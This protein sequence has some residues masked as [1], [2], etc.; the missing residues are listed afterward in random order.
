M[1]SGIDIVVEYPGPKLYV[2][3][4][5]TQYVTR[6]VTAVTTAYAPTRV[7]TSIVVSPVYR[8]VT[9]PLYRYYETW[10]RQWDAYQ[11]AWKEW[12]EK[13]EE[14]IRSGN[15]TLTEYSK[16]VSEKMTNEAR[17]VLARAIAELVVM[18]ESL[19]EDLYKKLRQVLENAYRGL[20]EGKTRIVV[21]P[22]I[23]KDRIELDVSVPHDLLLA[24]ALAG[25][26]HRKFNEY[27]ELVANEVANLGP[28]QAAEAVRMCLPKKVEELAKLVEE[29][30]LDQ[31]KPPQWTEWWWQ[32]A[33]AIKLVT[34]QELFDRAR[35]ILSQWERQGEELA[36]RGDIKGQLMQIA[37]AALKTALSGAQG[38][39]YALL[40]DLTGG[41]FAAPL[42]ADLAN[43]LNQLGNPLVRDL[44]L[45]ELREDPNALAE[46]IGSLVA[47][48]AAGAI[49][50]RAAGLART[51]LAKAVARI[52]KRTGSIK[53]AKL[54]EMIRGFTPQEAAKIVGDFVP[55]RVETKF[56]DT[57]YDPS[58]GRTYVVIFY[59]EAGKIKPYAKIPVEMLKNAAM[60][61]SRVVKVGDEN[62]AAHQILAYIAKRNLKPEEIQNLLEI[63]YQIPLETRS[64]MEFLQALEDAI[65]SGRPIYISGTK[66]KTVAIPAKSD[67][68]IDLEV[69]VDGR[70]LRFQ[71]PADPTA[72]PRV[73]LDPKLIEAADEL[74]KKENIPLSVALYRVLKERGVLKQMRDVVRWLEQ[75][76]DDL[77]ITNAKAVEEALSAPYPV[78]LEESTLLIKPAEGRVVTVAV[79]RG[80]IAE[81]LKYVTGR[82]V[83]DR[84]VSTMV[85]R[86]VA[87]TKPSGEVGDIYY[88]I[89]QKVMIS[90]D[91][92]RE[93]E[94]YFRKFVDAVTKRR[95][96]EAAQYVKQIVETAAK[97]EPETAVELGKLLESMVTTTRRG[98]VVVP[99]PVSDP[100]GTTVTI[101]GVVA[102]TPSQIESAIQRAERGEKVGEA[103]G[104]SAVAMQELK[105]VAEALKQYGISLEV[106]K[107]IDIDRVIAELQQAKQSIETAAEELQDEG[108][109]QLADYLQKTIID[110]AQ[111]KSLLLS[112]NRV[113]NRVVTAETITS[114]SM[115]E[116][117]PMQEARYRVLN[118][119]ARIDTAINVV[120]TVMTQVLDRVVRHILRETQR[121][122]LSKE[123]SL[124]ADV[125]TRRDIHVVAERHL[126]TVDEVLRHRQ[127]IDRIT[128]LSRENNVGEEVETKR[129]ISVVAEKHLKTVD[130][131]LRETQRLTE[132]KH[133]AKERELDASVETKRNIDVVAEKRLKQVDEVL[134]KTLPMLERERLT[135]ESELPT[136]AETDRS[137]NV[138]AEKH[139]KSIDRVVKQTLGIDRL[140]KLAKERSIDED[141]E[142]RRSISVVAE[143]HEKTVDEILR[144]TLGLS[145]V[146]SRSESTAVEKDVASKRDIK[147]VAERLVKMVD[148]ARYDRLAR[149]LVVELAD[150][151]RRYG[152]KLVERDIDIVAT[153]VRPDVVVFRRRRSTVSPI[154]QS[155]ST[156][157]PREETTDIELEVVNREV[158]DTQKVSTTTRS[159]SLTELS[160][161]TSVG[162]EESTQGVVVVVTQPVLE[163]VTEVVPVLDEVWLSWRRLPRVRRVSRPPSLPMVAAVPRIRR[164]WRKGRVGERVVL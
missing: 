81:L 75:H 1:S 30:K 18:S 74:A 2:T 103:V 90:R 51:L 161:C 140:T 87:E 58:T 79:G 33:R 141:V 158:T 80:R 29:G 102:A 49:G 116:T 88:T 149:R 99:M 123:T 13:Q 26:I 136:A 44:L 115:S 72:A 127:D 55:D 35:Q 62:Y 66:V 109:Q 34:L 85:Q 106:G 112:I 91:L 151:L 162:T 8:Y 96:D 97:T 69:A 89:R 124:S 113:V 128:K 110:L 42:L 31:V 37:A 131:V 142:T 117:L 40:I 93:I 135:K 118:A 73:W 107:R 71:I 111:L 67:K 46:F 105:S 150:E 10:Q 38:A 77:R 50:A 59:E 137:I 164:V 6:H 104:R 41:L 133:L 119:I 76:L 129:T 82:S 12:W 70:I 7:I 24:L 52:A 159:T 78:F 28:E 130:E 68:F 114:T 21:T 134:R 64:Q 122:K 146:E 14:T 63:V 32:V 9:V 148:D 92:W 126:K 94:P 86:V 147:V 19:P 98:S 47:G 139:L 144:S 156:S 65:R 45:K 57:V 108:L 154:D 16:K 101:L 121:T 43:Q 54:A 125:T 48:A 17:S 163:E 132:R 155:R 25:L 143:K 153:I 3:K 157:I 23:V 11:K 83:D 152:S 120:G 39:L 5:V 27:V 61:L 84:I 15:L 145:E 160:R 53:L 60:K 95:L 4:V 56:F 100:E 138:V 22:Y 20:Y 36:K